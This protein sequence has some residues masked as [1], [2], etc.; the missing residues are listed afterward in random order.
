MSG[1]LILPKNETLNANIYI[2]YESICQLLKQYGTNTMELDFFRVILDKYRRSARLNI[3]DCIAYC[4]F[5]KETFPRDRQTLYYNNGIQFR[6]VAEYHR[7]CSDLMMTAEVITTLFKNPKINKF[8]II[9]SGW[10]T[11]PLLRQ[12]K[13][14]NKSADAIFTKSDFDPSV[15]GYVE[16]Y[17]Y[18]E[19]LFHLTPEMTVSKADMEPET[20]AD[21]D[22][23]EQNIQREAMGIVKLLFYGSNSWWS[24]TRKQV[25]RFH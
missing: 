17:E 23:L 2:D 9:S 22:E 4:N 20:L 12:I 24:V 6:H 7:N 15:S 10:N 16:H 25:V 21:Q 5:E 1:Q 14:E 11:L 13:H 18:L 3:V 19:D 8:V